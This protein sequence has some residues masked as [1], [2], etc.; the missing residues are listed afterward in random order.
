MWLD[1]HKLMQAK[2]TDRTDVTQFLKMSTQHFFSSVGCLKKPL[3][4][5]YSQSSEIDSVLN[6]HGECII[7]V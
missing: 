1:L 2:G 5:C 6:V 7:N 4:E 3:M